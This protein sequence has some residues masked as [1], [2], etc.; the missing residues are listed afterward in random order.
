MK[1]DNVLVHG[2]AKM[3]GAWML[4]MDSWVRLFFSTSR[5]MLA[6]DLYSSRCFRKVG[7]QNDNT[8]TYSGGRAAVGR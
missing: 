7:V 5:T 8:D 4:A 2:S 1:L 3:C 6:V